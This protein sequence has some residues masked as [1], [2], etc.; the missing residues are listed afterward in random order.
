MP[1]MRIDIRADAV[2]VAT[3]A[4]DVICDAVRARPAARIGLPTGGTPLLTYR[5]LAEREAR[6]EVS[7]AQAIV[8][9]VDEFAGASRD[10]PGTNRVFYRQHLRVRPHARHCPDPAAPDPEAHIR[11]F[12]SA[13]RNDG[14]LD[15][16][17]LGIGANGHIAFNEP[18]AARDSRARVV[19]LD[20]VSRRAHAHTFGSLGRVPARGMTLGVADLFEARALLVIAQ[21]E[22]K[23]AIVRTAIEGEQTAA[24]PASWLQSHPNITWL[25]DAAAASQLA[26][27][28]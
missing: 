26:H 9:A 21:G 20:D 7:F 19:T 12:A 2:A 28:P 8:Y 13:M 14:G 17:V 15:L 11:T 23:A 3:R 5:E 25:L 4:A 27:H 1:P 16:C 18:G 10:T 24:V 6:R 22:N